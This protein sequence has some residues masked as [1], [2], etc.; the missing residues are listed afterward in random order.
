MDTFLW[1]VAWVLAV[2]FAG[3]GAMHALA[4][5]A[6]LDQLGWPQNYSAGQVKLIGVAELAAAAGLILPPLLDIAPILAPIAAAGICVIM[7]GAMITHYQR[8]EWPNLAFN[9][10]LLVLAALVVWGRF[11]P[12]A[13]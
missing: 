13:F 4:P 7:A 2:T 11:G 1:I 6:K 10:V 3:A 12:H 8:R 9:V 5:K